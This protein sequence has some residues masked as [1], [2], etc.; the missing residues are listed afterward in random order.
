MQVNAYNP[1]T[2]NIDVVSA[3]SDTHII[4]H[5]AFKKGKVYGLGKSSDQQT[6]IFILKKDLTWIQIIEHRNFTSFETLAKSE[7][8]DYVAV[9]KKNGRDYVEF[10]VLD[11]FSNKFGK[12]YDFTWTFVGNGYTKL[13]MSNGYDKAFIYD[14][15]RKQLFEFN[16]ISEVQYKP[17]DFGFDKR[18]NPEYCNKRD[19][20][21]K[22]DSFGMIYYHKYTYD[23]SMYKW[24]QTNY[25][26][27]DVHD[28][29]LYS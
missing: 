3:P 10:G 12:L 22:F 9:L 20:V 5:V 18:R 8:F 1:E 13:L 4:E 7:K 15:D 26:M 29:H 11:E 24:Y 27:A 25:D 17:I 21:L 6:G 23:S 28:S 19:C 14:A 2:N 16:S